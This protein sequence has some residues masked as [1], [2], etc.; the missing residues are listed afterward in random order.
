LLKHESLVSIPRVC[1]S[2][3]MEWTLILGISNQL[4]DA[5]NAFGLGTT[6]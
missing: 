6:L 3:G 1:D 2:V 4:L 5:N